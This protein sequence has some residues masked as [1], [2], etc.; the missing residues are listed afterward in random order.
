[1]VPPAR[2]KIELGGTWQPDKFESVRISIGV[3]VPCYSEELESAQEYWTAFVKEKMVEE[4]DKAK[5]WFDIQH[6]V[7]E[8]EPAQTEPEEPPF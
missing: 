6:G 8:A 3:D 5:E 4:R 1:M 2:V 7:A